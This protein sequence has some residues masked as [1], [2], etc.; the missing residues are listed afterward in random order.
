MLSF[1]ALSLSGLLSLDCPTE[2][3]LVE[4]GASDARLR[5]EFF[6]LVGS[7]FGL[8]LEGGTPHAHGCIFIGTSLAPLYFAE[9]QATVYPAPPLAFETFTLDEDGAAPALLPLGAIPEELCGQEFVVQGLFFDGQAPGG[10]S[11]TNGLR[12]IFGSGAPAGTPPAAPT[13]QTSVAATSGA[14]VSIFGFGTHPGSTVRI[15]GGGEVVDAVVDGLLRYEA[16]VALLPETK[17]LLSAKEIS[18]DGLQGPPAYVSVVQDG[19]APELHIDLPAAGALLP[20]QAVTVAGRV[21]DILSGSEGLEVEVNG[22]AAVVDIGIGTNGTWELSGVPLLDGAPTLLTVTARDVLGNTSTKTIAVSYVPPAGNSIAI[23]A[24]DGQVGDV[25]QELEHP[26][27]VQLV[28]ELGAA[29]PLAGKPVRFQVAQ[30]DGAIGVSPGAATERELVVESGADGTASVYWRLGSDAGCAN[31]RLAVTSGGFGSEVE[32]TASAL[33]GAPSQINVS[34]AGSPTCPAGAPSFDPLRVW[35]SDGCNGIAG[36]PVT[37]RVTQGAGTVGGLPELT[38]ATGPTGHAEV[39]FYAGPGMAGGAEVEVVEADFPGNGGPP[40]TFVMRALTA[41]PGAPASLRGI[42]LDNAGEPI[43]D[44]HC[45]LAIDGLLYETSTASNGRFEFPAILTQGPAALHVD[46]SEVG[47][48][49]ALHFRFAIVAGA[50][51]EMSAP[52][53]IPRLDPA[54]ERSYSTKK[55]TV[56]EVVGVE[57]FRVIVEPGSMTIGGE[58]AP[59][60]ATLSLDQVHFDDIPMPMPDGAT[61]LLAWTLQPAGAR[62]APPAR[63]EYPNVAGLPPGAASSFLSF[64]HA[65]ERFEIVASGRVSD[66]GSTIVSDPGDGIGIAGWGGNCPPYSVTGTVQGKNCKVYIYENG[67]PARDQ[68]VCLGEEREY[69]AAGGPAG[70]EYSWFVSGAGAEVIGDT[71][72]PNLRVRFSNEGNVVVRVFYAC[73][74]TENGPGG[75]DTEDVSIDV[76]SEDVIL[77]SAETGWDYVLPLEDVSGDTVAPSNRFRFL[78]GGKSPDDYRTLEVRY[79]SDAQGEFLCRITPVGGYTV[80]ELDPLEELLDAEGTAK[81]QLPFT[82]RPNPTSAPHTDD[83]IPPISFDVEVFV[84][85]GE[86]TVGAPVVGPTTVAQDVIDRMRQEYFDMRLFDPTNEFRQGIDAVVATGVPPRGQCRVPKEK[87]Q[88]SSIELGGSKGCSC[89]GSGPCPNYFDGNE[90]LVWDGGLGF[91][92]YQIDQLASSQLLALQPPGGGLSSLGIFVSSGHRSP[93]H[94]ACTSGVID[95]NHQWGRALDL[96][97]TFGGDSA[98]D[99]W[100]ALYLAALEA[101]TEDGEVLLERNTAQLLPENWFPPIPI[102]G[103]FE[104]T[105]PATGELFYLVDSAFS[106]IGGPF[107]FGDPGDLIAESVQATSPFGTPPPAGAEI[108]WPPDNFEDIALVLVAA[109]GSADPAKPAARWL[110]K[111]GGSLIDVEAQFLFEATHV[112]VARPAPAR[113][114]S[115][116]RRGRP[117]WPR[118]NARPGPGGR[119]A[120][121]DLD[122]HRR[123][124]DL[125]RARGRHLHHPQ[126]R[127]AGPLRRRGPRVRRRLRERLPDVRP[128]PAR[129]RGLGRVRGEHALLRR[130]GLADADRPARGRGRAAAGPGE[131]GDLRRG[132]VAEPGPAGR[133]DPPGTHGGRVRGRSDRRPLDDLRHQQPGRGP[134]PAGLR[135]GHLRRPGVD[136]RRVPREHERGDGLVQPGRRRRRERVRVPARRR[137]GARRHRP[138]DRNGR[139]RHDRVRRPLPADGRGRGERPRLAA[140]QRS[141]R[142]SRRRRGNAGPDRRGGRARR[143]R[144]HR[145]P[146]PGRR[147]RLP[148]PR[149]RRELG[150]ARAG[151]RPRRRPLGRPHR[152]ELLGDRPARAP[153]R[154]DRP[155]LR[156]RDHRWRDLQLATRRGRPER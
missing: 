131:R 82:H 132:H 14:S 41:Q 46:P 11:F 85:D 115:P 79:C 18:P 99:R 19:S 123:G 3:Q 134:G 148:L 7:P 108:L 113:G 13:A 50:E 22:Q 44:A 137:A 12:L 57:G 133:A 28:D 127:P 37:F 35:V 101:A 74:D 33:P 156:G 58:P 9:F 120:R 64:D 111:W 88:F 126:H 80:A 125:P 152:P 100:V 105:H 144:S 71:E 67:E 109:D 8:D 117:R 10:I 149:H 26:V 38:V 73:P 114:R 1:L 65:T 142:G 106:S 121:F 130:P 23:S 110:L 136:R 17:N 39:P 48:F 119:R 84:W 25:L 155:A 45:E 36:V 145:R 135:G 90:G 150:L 86:Q 76:A 55:N 42:V 40:G 51:N 92:A 72:G 47:P 75:S 69:T 20:A 78:V 31:N 103:K 89:L 96:V 2:A 15:E 66:D 27:T 128:G 70:G 54:N 43:E 4:L 49:P 59:E 62:F 68:A 87:G 83:G 112:H 29:L 102:Q 138:S 147:A 139:L 107:G 34:A 24:G 104:L 97:P 94:N 81:F 122:G 61:P 32:V 116:R 91:L 21:A 154:R 124:A 141:G 95:S 16:E 146:P 143:R 30:S 153:E 93:S 63:I 52:V 151:R 77:A 56:L 5:S 6:P 98:L 53:R 140:G 129:V 60:G 118:R